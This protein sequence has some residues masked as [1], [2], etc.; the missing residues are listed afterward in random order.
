MQCFQVL[1][2]KMVCISISNYLLCLYN[3]GNDFPDEGKA[4]VEEEAKATEIRAQDT[5][6]EARAAENRAQIAAEGAKVAE[7]QFRAQQA[8]IQVRMG[9][10]LD[11]C[12]NNWIHISSTNCTGIGCVLSLIHLILFVSGQ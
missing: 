2:T 6:Q 9:T 7:Q 11:L 3:R 12:K 8:Q 10:H 5:A 4:V 1:F